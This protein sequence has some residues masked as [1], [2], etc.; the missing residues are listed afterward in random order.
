M[1]TKGTMQNKPIVAEVGHPV[2]GS[3]RLSKAKAQWYEQAR[4]G[5]LPALSEKQLD[6]PTVPFAT[7]PPMINRELL[8]LC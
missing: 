6:D 3:V 5:L 7:A 4:C 1:N 8:A 2:S